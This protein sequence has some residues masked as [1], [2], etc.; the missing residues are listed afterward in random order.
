MNSREKV[1]AAVSRNQPS[2][3]AL[4]SL[5]HLQ[6]IRY[7][8]KKAQFITV[9]EGIGAK[10][11]AVSNYEA[12]TEYITQ[13]FTEGD[14]YITTIPALTGIPQ[15]TSNPDPHTLENL[16]VAVIPGL[17]GVAEN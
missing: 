9:V 11:Q 16:E 15:L 17:F 12:V 4:P 10:V 5:A 14:Q 13:H 1:L 6:P 7:E 2:T 3:R 8:D